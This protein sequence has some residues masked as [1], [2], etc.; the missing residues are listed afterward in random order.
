MPNVNTYYQVSGAELT[1]MDRGL[2]ADIAKAVNM[3]PET[4]MARP[5]WNSIILQEV[6]AAP[7][8]LTPQGIEKVAYRAFN[9]INTQVA[10]AAKEDFNRIIGQP[11]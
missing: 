7:L 9:R 5:R 4:I 1:E 3:A 8:P 2:I 6:Y 11:S 10:L